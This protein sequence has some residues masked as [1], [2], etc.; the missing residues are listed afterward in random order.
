MYA[1]AIWSYKL[2]LLLYPFMMAGRKQTG[3]HTYQVTPEVTITLRENSGDVFILW[4]TFN[5]DA[6]VHKGFEMEPRDVVV[7][8]GAHIGIF[9]VYAARKVSKGTVLS[10][11]PEPDS[12]QYL[13]KNKEQNS[14]SNLKI[15]NLAIT[16]TGGAV[17]LHISSSNTGAHSIYAVD[18]KRIIKVPSVTL[19]DVLAQNALE[20]INYLKMDAEGAE[21]DVILNT[22]RDVLHKVDKIVMEYHDFLSTGHSHGQIVRRLQSCGFQVSVKGSIIKRKFFKVGTILAKRS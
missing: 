5:H 14:L 2:G 21:F 18:T 15:F 8:I 20:R 11:E 13:Q 3:E 12:C 19:E 7:D 4:E 22:P 1:P 17:D 6:Y 16:S 9:A 10:Y